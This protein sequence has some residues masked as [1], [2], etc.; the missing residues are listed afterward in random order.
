MDATQVAA[1]LKV[2]LDKLTVSF[3]NELAQKQN[4]I[5]MLNAALLKQNNTTN[6]TPAHNVRKGKERVNMPEEYKGDRKKTLHFLYQTSIVFEAQAEVYVD[7]AS[8][9]RFVCSYLKGSAGKWAETQNKK[10]NFKN[11]RFDDFKKMLVEAFGEFDS[12]KENLDKIK[13]LKQTGACADY[14]MQFNIYASETNLD[15]ISKLDYFK[16]G[17]KEKLLDLMVTI[18]E[19]DTVSEYQKIAIK[20]DNRIHDREVKRRKGNNPNPNRPHPPTEPKKI[21]KTIDNSTK[22]EGPAPMDL[23][24]IQVMITNAVQSAVGYKPRS[25]LTP[26]Q[27]EH[28]RVNKL[29]IYCGG[30][31]CGGFPDVKECKTLQAKNAGKSQRQT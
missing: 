11:I 29:C 15:E 12:H 5:D 23:D 20:F 10:G 8:K 4:D 16:E 6:S 14:T 3:R 7:D 13:T 22:V 18:D 21:I 27:R 9:I 24:S 19:P 17:L 31:S 25:S 1:F 2:E 28:R 30:D 26:D